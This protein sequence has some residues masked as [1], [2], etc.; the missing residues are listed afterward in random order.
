V[1]ASIFRF[2][3]TERTTFAATR[4]VPRALNL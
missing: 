4:H 3:L 2:L 1:S